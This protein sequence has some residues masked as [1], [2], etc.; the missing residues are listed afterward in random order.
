MRNLKQNEKELLINLF[1]EVEGMEPEAAAKHIWPEALKQCKTLVYAT[2]K[3]SIAFLVDYANSQPADEVEDAVENLEA[4]LTATI[5]KADD[6]APEAMYTVKD[7]AD[8][9]GLTPYKARVALR[10]A[11]G[12]AKGRWQWNSEEEYQAA[13]DAVGGAK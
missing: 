2:K 11:F 7:L 5:T 1:N 8:E 10:K 6:E 12:K 9:L 13:L 4:D 3:Q